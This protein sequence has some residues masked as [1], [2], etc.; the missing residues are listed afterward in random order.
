MRFSLCSS[1]PLDDHLSVSEMA[2]TLVLELGI[3]PSKAHFQDQEES[4]G[5]E[6]LCATP[7]NAQATMHQRRSQPSSIRVP[8]VGLSPARWPSKGTEYTT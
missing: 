2:K 5:D 4:A 3:D 1:V 6:T 8:S 7:L